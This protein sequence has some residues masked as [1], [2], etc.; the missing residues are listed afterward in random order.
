VYHNQQVVGWKIEEIYHILFDNLLQSHELWFVPNNFHSHPGLL[1]EL[2][3]MESNWDCNFADR[4]VERKKSLNF[5]LLL[6]MSDALRF[7][8]QEES[9]C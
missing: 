6:E 9:F 8:E 2:L 3:N 5:L 4:Y 1:Q 7:F